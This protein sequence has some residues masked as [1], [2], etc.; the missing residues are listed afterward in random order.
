M[1][2]QTEQI[3]QDIR[4][5]LRAKEFETRE[6]TRE[7]YF[8][9]DTGMDSLDFIEMIMEIE[10]KFN[11]SIPDEDYEKVQTLGQLTDYVEERI[12]QR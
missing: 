5:I 4:A 9:G 3:E 12:Q 10:T 7:T 8:K 6:T 1:P 11:I 2:T